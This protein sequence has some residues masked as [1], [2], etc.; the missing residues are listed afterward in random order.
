M[1]VKDWHLYTKE[2]VAGA[3]KCGQGKNVDLYTVAS[4]EKVLKFESEFDKR[5]ID[6]KNP[7]CPSKTK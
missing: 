5:V 3:C 6:C 1:S 7:N 2:N 4:H